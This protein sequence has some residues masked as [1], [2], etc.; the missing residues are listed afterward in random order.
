MIGANILIVG[1][2]QGTV[3]DFDGYYEL[4]VPHDDPQIEVSYTGYDTKNLH[5]GNSEIV[6]VTLGASSQLL[7]E[8][9]VIGYG[10]VSRS[11][12]TTAAL[13][14]ES[15]VSIAL[16]GK[17]S[18][19]NIRGSRS[20]STKYLVDGIDVNGISTDLRSPPNTIRTNFND[21]AYWQPHLLTDA[22]GR[23]KFEVTFPEDITTWRQYVLTS[24]RRA[25]LGLG[26]AFTQS[27]LPLQAQL[28]TPRFLVEGDRSSVIGLLAN[29][30]GQSLPSTTKLMEV[31]Q[32]DQVRD[33]ELELSQ[34]QIFEL[35][36]VDVGQDS[37]RL[38]Y[39]I[40]ADDFMDGEQRSIPVFR[41]GTVRRV[42]QFQVL[43]DD[44]EVGIQADPNHG[45][46]TLRVSG[47]SLPQLLENIAYLRNYRYHCNEQTASR[48]I[49]LLAAQ[50]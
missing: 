24:D 6:D 10:T 48:L 13:T 27:Y 11:K 50:D 5:I 32:T 43:H 46:V 12:S 16:Q 9:V 20:I 17:V 33:L 40:Q 36:P 15:P 28:Y 14:I 29:R 19:L 49:A 26:Q 4:W 30:T 37:V 47:N 41:R 23:A 18:G 8:V 22:R 44:G 25:R 35:S 42:G 7:D 3:T 45:P 1:T 31:G 38:T 21:N 2:S 39:Q 34:Q